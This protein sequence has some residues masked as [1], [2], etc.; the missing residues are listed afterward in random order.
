MSVYL[1]QRRQK[2][3][4]MS[5][6]KKTCFFSRAD[7]AEDL[8]TLGGGGVFNNLRVRK[9]ILGERCCEFGIDV[10]IARFGG[11]RRI[12]EFTLWSAAF[13]GIYAYRVCE[14]EFLCCAVFV[15][16]DRLLPVDSNNGAST[17]GGNDFGESRCVTHHC[18]CVAADFTLKRSFAV[19]AARGGGCGVGH[20]NLCRT[21]NDWLLMEVLVFHVSG[22]M[23]QKL[24]L[25]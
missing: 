18:V 15:G 5:I 4:Q 7:C 17:R 9:V 8:C 22:N 11:V 24:K 12:N 25:F 16:N 23:K 14:Y 3:Y 6:S 19:A 13:C 21:E 20:L 2:L 10:F 1:R